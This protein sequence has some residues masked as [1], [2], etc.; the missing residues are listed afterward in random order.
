MARSKKVE[1][2]AAAEG[3]GGDAAGSASEEEAGAGSSPKKEK[4]KKSEKS[5][6]DEDEDDDKEIG[7]EHGPRKLRQRVHTLRL[8][9]E[10]KRGGAR[11]ELEPAPVEALAVEALLP[12]GVPP[13]LPGNV[14]FDHSDHFL[15]APMGVCAA[16]SFGHLPFHGLRC[17]SRLRFLDGGLD[18]AHDP[19]LKR[20]KKYFQFF[21]LFP[22]SFVS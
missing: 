15:Y 10:G 21:G 19:I 11:T 3:E 4:S 1:P 17:W 22:K 13:D 14:L 6:K 2:D 18:R 8:R 7:P 9:L 5:K 12:L 16:A 20:C